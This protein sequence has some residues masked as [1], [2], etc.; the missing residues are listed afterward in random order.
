[1]EEVT[2]QPPTVDTRTQPAEGASSEPRRDAASRDPEEG[3]CSDV[4]GPDDTRGATHTAH[5][6]AP[7]SA[8]PPLPVVR[9][10]TTK[11]LPASAVVPLRQRH[12]QQQQQ[13]LEQQQQWAESVRESLLK[14]QWE[15]SQAAYNSAEEEQDEDP[16][17]TTSHLDGRTT[18]TDTSTRAAG[19]MSHAGQLMEPLSPGHGPW[20]PTRQ[21][22]GDTPSSLVA[23]AAERRM[24]PSQHTERDRYRPRP[25]HADGAATL[26]EA[27][28]A[29]VSQ[30]K[31]YGA[32]RARAEQRQRGGDGAGGGG[33]SIHDEADRRGASSSAVTQLFQTPAQL[34]Q[35]FWRNNG[36]TEAAAA[37]A[38][39]A[40][41]K[42]S[43]A[44]AEWLT[45]DG[46][47]STS[48]SVVAAVGRSDGDSLALDGT[49]SMLSA[50]SSVMPAP[51]V[52]PLQ[53]PAG[54]SMEEFI[55]K[56]ASTDVQLNVKAKA[57]NHLV[58]RPASR[59]A[60]WNPNPNPNPNLSLSPDPNPKPSHRFACGNSGHRLD[61]GLNRGDCA[62]RSSLCACWLSAQG[63][64]LF[65][66]AVFIF[67][68]PVGGLGGRHAHH[69]AAA[70]RHDHAHGLCRGVRGDPGPPHGVCA[71][72]PPSHPSTIHAACRSCDLHRV[73]SAPNHPMHGTD[74]YSW[75]AVGSSR[76][77]YAT[78]FA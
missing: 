11:D 58:V 47:Q 27:A 2:R 49:E 39:A 29:T 17:D 67:A 60:L 48:S 18:P 14:A 55:A 32:G 15:M 73:I 62:H 56:L 23:D 57:G 26:G 4:V 25:E 31:L 46:A 20:G 42:P 24:S 6:D 71:L 51:S 34:L 12:L 72:P 66:F 52:A 3:Q 70:G 19:V 10:S 63:L 41:T 1:M 76:T 65:V 64:I 37:A 69:A 9:P 50:M 75:N 33:G 8:K 7:A 13:Q 30:S 16:T 54:V 36:A 77:R 40:A 74:G 5:S 22:V 38:A 28:A 45:G 68:G 53:I 21:P 35:S 61:A 78:R 59:V 43:S 44:A